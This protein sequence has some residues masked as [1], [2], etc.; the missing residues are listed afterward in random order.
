LKTRVRSHV[1]CDVDFP[2]LYWRLRLIGGLPGRTLRD[3]TAG[4]SRRIRRSI[5]TRMCASPT[6]LRP[7]PAM[8]AKRLPMTAKLLKGLWDGLGVQQSARCQVED[9][10]K[11]L[12]CEVRPSVQMD[13]VLITRILSVVFW[14]PVADD[15]RY[16]R[17][18][19]IVLLKFVSFESA[20]ELRNAKSCDMPSSG[21]ICGA[22]D[23]SGRQLEG[24]S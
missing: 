22:T 7:T 9:R 23:V 18:C 12:E 13:A 14:L 5:T 1:K 15:T 10:E 19:A 4:T 24:Q 16:S 3:L 21:N 6:S 2:S 17:T 20:F 11:D 8:Q